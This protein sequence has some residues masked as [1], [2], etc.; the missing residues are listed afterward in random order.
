MNEAQH[1]AADRRHAAQLAR[2]CRAMRND[3]NRPWEWSTREWNNQVRITV[4][5]YLHNVA[6][7]RRANGG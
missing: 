1:R 6:R 4:R 5:H 7:F 2:D 3:K